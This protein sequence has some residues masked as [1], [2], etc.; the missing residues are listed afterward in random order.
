MNPFSLMRPRRTGP[1]TVS[2]AVFSSTD[3]FALL[4]GFDLGCFAASHGSVDMH[5]FEDRGIG[6]WRSAL[7]ERWAPTGLVDESGAPCPELA[8]ALSPL[9]PP[10]SVVMDGDYITERHPI[11]RRTV[12]VCVDAAGERVTGIARAR[13]G[14][15]LVPFGPDR[16]S[17]P[18]RFERVFGLERSFQNSMWTQHYIEGDFRLDDES[19]ADHLIGG[20]R[21]AREYAL[22]KGVDPEP[23]ADLGRAFHN[24]FGGLTM[25]TLTAMNLTDCSFLEGL[26]YV[27]PHPV[28]G[29][30]KSK[31]SGILP[32]KGFIMFNGC[33]PRR[34]YPEDWVKHSEFKSGS[35]FGGFDFI[36]EGMTLMDTVLTFCDYPE[37]D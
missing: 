27:L 3:L 29:W 5:V 12:A 37:G 14:Y 19:L 4:G 16:A 32:E 17:W 2:T 34:G 35:R 15:R 13:G 28:G 1:P 6:P 30:P 21:T 9:S 20:E 24:P 22:E 23:L 31:V 26:G 25:R 10:G 11:D 36:G 8:W 7:I 18:A 33:A